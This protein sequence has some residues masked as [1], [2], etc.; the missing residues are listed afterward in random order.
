[1]SLVYLQTHRGQFSIQATATIVFIYS[2][3]L[4]VIAGNLMLFFGSAMKG[5]F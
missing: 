1:M 3:A 5:A 2:F 4:F